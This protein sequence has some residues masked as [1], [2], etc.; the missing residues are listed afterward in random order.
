VEV[1]EGL[2]GEH[3]CGRGEMEN[4]VKEPLIVFADRRRPH[5]QISPDTFRPSREVPKSW[6]EDRGLARQSKRSSTRARRA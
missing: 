2:Y 1:A 3:Y 5:H 4:R 6:R